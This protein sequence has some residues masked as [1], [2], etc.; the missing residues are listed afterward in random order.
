MTG[1][2]T[3]PPA[4]SIWPF[5]AWGLCV[6]GAVVRVA[7]YARNRSLW[8]DEAAVALNIA[9]RGFVGLLAPLDYLQTAP[10]LFLWLERAAVLAFGVNEWALRLVPLLAGIATPP[11]MWRVG[12]RVLPESA[13]TLAVGLVALS[14]ALARYS[15]EVKPY[16]LDAL[17]TLLILDHALAAMDP[18]GGSKRWWTLAATGIVSVA[19][20]TPAV[21]V[22]A[23]GV[24]YLA[25]TGVAVRDRALVR[26]AAVLA[27][28][29][30]ATFVVLATTIFRPLLRE[31]SPIG[32]FM[33]WYWAANFLTSDPPGFVSKALALVWS[34][35]P[36]TFLGEGIIPNA[37]SL[38][39]LLIVVAVVV[40][41]MNHQVPRVLLLIIPF[42]LLAVASMLR[43]YPMAQRLMLFGAPLSA[44]LVASSQ[45]VFGRA[46][47]RRAG[48]WPTAMVTAT[49]LL[50][51]ARGLAAQ[52]NSR[53]GLQES[54]ALVR[55][56]AVRHASGAPLWVSG[57]GEAAWRFYTRWGA[58]VASRDS[59]AMVAVAQRAPAADLIV[60]SW[61]ASRP[62][63][64]LTV[65]NDTAAARRPSAWSEKEARRI[66]ALARPCA[67]ILLAHMQPGEAAALLA[68]TTALG[69]RLASSQ[70]KPGAELHEVCFPARADPVPRPGTEH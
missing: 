7:L 26:H 24:V 47:W 60:G 54:R 38:F 32:R 43:L 34:A 57:G 18:Q 61:Y 40:L 66:R 36:D 19:V 42:A 69:G 27:A 59:G 50:L 44:L 21:F 1:G 17:V 13:A 20:S 67:L 56:A 48:A 5:I 53:S 55:E 30:G 9:G 41:V 28:V 51:A 6:A 52:F 22:L 70:R 63:R 4:P 46:L 33:H 62:E 58:P 65:S 25:A 35:L 37:T 64:I 15:V 2:R 31:S 45:L 8:Y 49:I 23:G 3:K 10:P 11:M 16:A 39:L 14:P 29:W 12:R 68:S